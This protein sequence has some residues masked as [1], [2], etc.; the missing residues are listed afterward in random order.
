MSAEEMAGAINGALPNVKKGTLRFFG[1]WFGRQMDN[2]HSIVA[3]EADESRLCLTFNEDETLDIW[4]PENLDLEPDVL[5]VIRS[6]SRVRWEWF[7]YGR[8]KTPDNRYFIEY[9]R[10][11]NAIHRDTDRPASM[12]SP[13]TVDPRAP[14]VTIN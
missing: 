14:A 7:Y 3:A 12:D 4:D 13:P 11:D 10:V 9:R 2:I 6:A 8:P 1:D 5:F